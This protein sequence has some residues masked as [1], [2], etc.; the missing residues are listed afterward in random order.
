VSTLLTLR[1]GRFGAQLET[2]R[3][4]VGFRI[5]R[6]TPG[7]IVLDFRGSAC[8]WSM[9][10]ASP[11]TISSEELMATNPEWTREEKGGLRSS[12]R[13]LEAFRQL[14]GTMPTQRAALL[15]QVALNEGM[16]STELLPRVG[17]SSS[18]MA[19][20]VESLGPRGAG[21]IEAITDAADRRREP[22]YLT[23]KGRAFMRTLL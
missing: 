23:T 21:L 3:D 2:H 17:I 8:R 7:E 15:M 11:P 4:K 9:S 14:D 20:H 22:L 10:G 16:T 12:L 5:E 1:L 18:A 13:L 6:P 19:R